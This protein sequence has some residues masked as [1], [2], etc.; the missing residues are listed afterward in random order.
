MSEMIERVAKRLFLSRYSECE[1]YW[2][3]N[4]VSVTVETA[5]SYRDYAREALQELRE[6]TEDMKAAYYVDN[7][8]DYATGWH[9]MIDAAI[10]TGSMKPP[11]DLRNL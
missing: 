10:S 7:Y 6:P 4:L 5:D 8:G 9:A 1:E 2:P 11:T 3:D